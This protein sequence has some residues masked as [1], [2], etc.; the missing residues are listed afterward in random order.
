M[1]SDLTVYVVVNLQMSTSQ[2][3]VT[4]TWSLFSGKSVLVDCRFKFLHTMWLHV[5]RLYPLFALLLSVA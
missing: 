2:D 5:T 3:L 1:V 4:K